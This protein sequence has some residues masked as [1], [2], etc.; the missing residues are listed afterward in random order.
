MGENLSDILVVLHLLWAT[1]MIAGVPLAIVGIFRPG[2]RR[3]MKLRT[4]HLAG[5]V[6]TASVP[7]WGGICP[8]TRWEDLLRSGA[9]TTAVR[10]FL[11]DVAYRLL[12][13]NVPIWVITLATSVIALASVVLYFL[14]PPWRSTG[15]TQIDR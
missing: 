13:V 11:A 5:I 3:L 4:I 7:L 9:G 1:F 2:W 8:L 6:F 14:Y 15:N 12:Y 10:S